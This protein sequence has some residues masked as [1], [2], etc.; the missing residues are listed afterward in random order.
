MNNFYRSSKPKMP[1]IKNV[2]GEIVDT[3]IREVPYSVA[4]NEDDRF[5]IEDYRDQNCNVEK[6]VFDNAEYKEIHNVIHELNEEEKKIIYGIYF[7]KIS[8]TELSANMGMSQQKLAYKLKKTLNKMR[9]IYQE[10][11]F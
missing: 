6:S 11:F 2:E 4:S 1:V 8:Q 3:R 5:S 9:Y 10:K 7:E